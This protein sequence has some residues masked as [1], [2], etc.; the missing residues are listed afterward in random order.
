MHITIGNFLAW[1]IIYVFCF[2]VTSLL[3]YI[4]GGA[5]SIDHNIGSSLIASAIIFYAI[6]GSFQYADKAAF[7]EESRK[8][9]L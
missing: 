7:N 2:S 3:L 6:I 8:T 1:L 5:D 4:V 9:R